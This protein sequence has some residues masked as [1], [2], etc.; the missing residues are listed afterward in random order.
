MAGTRILV[1]DNKFV[2]FGLGAAFRQFL[3]NDRYAEI[4][5]KNSS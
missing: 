3:L 2:R 1:D 4:V 5:L